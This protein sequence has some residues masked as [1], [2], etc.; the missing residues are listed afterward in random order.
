M[1]LDTRIRN[2]G[3]FQSV[4]TLEQR[5]CFLACDAVFDS[6]AQ[7]PP[8]GIWVALLKSRRARVNQFVAFALPLGDRASRP[9]DVGPCSRV[10]TI[11]EQRAGPDVDRKLVLSGEVVIEAAQQQLFEASFAIVLR[12]EI[13][14]C[15]RVRVG[16]HK[17]ESTRSR[18]RL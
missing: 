3:G 18:T 6:Q 2:A 8:G 17:F 10:T 13:G 5:E 9:L 12:F 15:R 7:Q 16:S 1:P 11:D 4:E 14:R